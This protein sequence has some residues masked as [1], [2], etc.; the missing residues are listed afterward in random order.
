[1]SE[2]LLR[3][4]EEGKFES[5][6]P[7]TT[8]SIDTEEDWKFLQEALKKAKAKLPYL[9]GDGYA[10]GAMVYDMWKCPNCGME[11]EMEYEEHK[12][13]PECGQAIKWN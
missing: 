3:P 8:I 10:D 13:C 2:I 7:Y 5:Y 1:M 6:E 12:Y 4:N 11:Y 9:S